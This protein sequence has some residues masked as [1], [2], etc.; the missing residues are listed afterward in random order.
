MRRRPSAGL[1]ARD[2][3]AEGRYAAVLDG[4]HLELTLVSHRSVDVVRLRGIH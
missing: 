3:S 1:A 4:A 2:V